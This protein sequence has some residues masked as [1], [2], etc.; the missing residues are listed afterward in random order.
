MDAEIMRQ[1]DLAGG[2]R[3]SEAATYC[4][5]EYIGWEGGGPRMAR[6]GLFSNLQY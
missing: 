4:P 2:V 6:E 3:T 1:R 5:N